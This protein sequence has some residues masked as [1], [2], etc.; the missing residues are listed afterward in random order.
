MSDHDK[1]WGSVRT[2]VEFFLGSQEPVLTL[3]GVLI[4]ICLD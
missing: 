4:F 3:T 2:G 1:P